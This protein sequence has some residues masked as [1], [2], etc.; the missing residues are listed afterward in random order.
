MKITRKMLKIGEKN[1][2]K[3]L[4]VDIRK[5]FCMNLWNS[6]IDLQKPSQH[7]SIINVL[8][9]VL[10]GNRPKSPFYWLP[11]QRN[12]KQI[13]SDAFCIIWTKVY[14]YVNKKSPPSPK[15]KNLVRKT[16]QDVYC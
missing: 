8:Q 5:I 13:R 6:F 16:V 1:R 15:E 9:K 7:E 10:I 11:W 2:Q 14:L 4:N 3:F 12:K